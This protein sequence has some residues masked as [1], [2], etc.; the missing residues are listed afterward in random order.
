MYH[1]MHIVTI[2]LCVSRAPSGTRQPL[3]SPLL[4]LLRG[5]NHIRSGKRRHPGRIDPFVRALTSSL[6]CPKLSLAEVGLLLYV[7]VDLLLN[8]KV[9]SPLIRPR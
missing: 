6:S 7:A 8:L 3:S 1:N 9:A 2:R 5:R 4:G